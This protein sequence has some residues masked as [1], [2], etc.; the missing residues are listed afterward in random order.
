MYI[1]FSGMTESDFQKRFL[2]P[3][4]RQEFSL[5]EQ[6]CTYAWHG[7]HHYEQIKKLKERKKW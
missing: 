5:D 4:H 3:E 6:L 1:L 2:H 7:A